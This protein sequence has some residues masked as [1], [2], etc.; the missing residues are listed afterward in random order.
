MGI[1]TFK[2]MSKLQWNLSIYVVQQYQWRKYGIITGRLRLYFRR[3]GFRK[4]TPPNLG[5][6][7]SLITTYCWISRDK[8]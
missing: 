1:L 7:D 6:V 3:Y 8:L 4:S 2:E 5:H